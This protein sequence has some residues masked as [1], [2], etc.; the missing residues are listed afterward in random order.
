M[1]GRDHTKQLTD[2]PQLDTLVDILS[3]R[4]RRR[5]SYTSTPSQDSIDTI[6]PNS[7]ISITPITQFSYRFNMMSTPGLRL[8]SSN[9]ILNLY[10]LIKSSD[11]TPKSDW[12]VK[13]H[14]LST[15]RSGNQLLAEWS[16]IRLRP[17]IMNGHWTYLYQSRRLGDTKSPLYQCQ[18]FRIV[19][20]LF[21]RLISSSRRWKSWSRPGS[22]R[23]RRLG[24]F[25]LGT[26]WTSCFRVKHLGLSSK[27]LSSQN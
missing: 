16:R 27:L 8:H 20:R 14:L 13:R 23:Y 4:H 24:I 2:I 10:V 22:F 17:T 21:T 9:P 12:K 1:Q 25:A 5:G 11:Q 15:S 7:K 6:S 19:N 26:I 3:N 18:M